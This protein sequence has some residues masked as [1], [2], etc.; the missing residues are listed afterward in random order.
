MMVCVLMLIWVV[1]LSSRCLFVLLFMV[2]IRVMGRFSCVRFLVM[3]CIM[4]L[5]VLC[6]L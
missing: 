3:L 6:D 2:V 1:C 4:L 5:G